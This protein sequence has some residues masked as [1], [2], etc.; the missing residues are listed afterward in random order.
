MNSKAKV[1]D[2]DF[3]DAADVIGIQVRLHPIDCG[4]DPRAH[5][6]TIEV[7]LVRGGPLRVSYSDPQGGRRVMEGPGA[8][9]LA[10][11]RALGYRV[12][13]VPPGG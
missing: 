1:V 7:P 5:G 9:V 4:F 13:P 10:R 11:L 3:A 2:V 8:A 12:R 6:Q